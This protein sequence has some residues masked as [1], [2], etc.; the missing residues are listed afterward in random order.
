MRYLRYLCVALLLTVVADAQPATARQPPR[1]PDWARNLAGVWQP[2][3]TTPGTWEEANRGSGLGGTGVDPAAPVAPSS[4]DRQT[5]EGAPY[6]EWAAKKVL[7]A[8]N[9]RGIDDP[10]AQCLPPGIPRLYSVGLFPVKIIQS[11]DQI[12][13]L[14]EYMNVFRIIPLNAKH[15]DDVEPTYLGDSVAHWEGDTLV[16]DMTGFNEKTWLVGGGTFHSDK[17]HITERYRRVNK[18]RIDYE[19]VME[20]PE[21]LTKPWVYRTSLMLRNGTRLHEYACAENNLDP[22]RY[23]QMQKDGVKFQR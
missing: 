2:N 7:E 14:Y 4:S 11:P 22:G 5:R 3:S 13:I 17:L 20:D 1:R 8:F 9:R 19:A 16:V 10:T 6:Q 21:V 12:V 23:E 15:P 18:D